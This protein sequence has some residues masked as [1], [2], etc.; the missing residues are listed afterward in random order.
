MLRKLLCL[1]GFHKYH[2]PFNGLGY[3]CKCG[4]IIHY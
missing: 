4:K 2:K 1:L 3:Q